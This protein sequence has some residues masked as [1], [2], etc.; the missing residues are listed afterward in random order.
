MAGLCV[1][2]WETF[3]I[4]NLFDKFVRNKFG[5]RVALAPERAARRGEPHGWGEQS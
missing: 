4:S 3:R 5:Q 2:G 1:S